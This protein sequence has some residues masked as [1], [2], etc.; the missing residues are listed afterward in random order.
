M[1]LYSDLKA[2]GCKLDSHESDLYVKACPEACEI[3]SRSGHIW[4]YFHSARDNKLWIECPFAF[5]P[6]WLSR[7]PRKGDKERSERI[8]VKP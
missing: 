7:F 2:A 8:Q 1:S 3:V 6:W 4:D 5:D